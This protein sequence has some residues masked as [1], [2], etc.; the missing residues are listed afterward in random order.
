MR[1]SRSRLAALSPS[2]HRIALAGALGAS[3]CLPVW[4]AP[5]APVREQ[6]L[7]SIE[8]PLT[9][10]DAGR[11]REIFSLQATADWD[12][13]DRLIAEVEDRRLLGHVLAGRYL[14]PTDYRSRYR[15]L[16]AW[17]ERY[18]D[19]PD[20]ERIHKLAL[21]RKPE[22]SPP[23]RRPR[24]EETSLAAEPP[25]DVVYLYR[26]KKRLSRSDWRQ[27][28]RLKWRIRRN[29]RRVY[30]SKTERMLESAELRRLFDDF[31]RD[32]AYSQLAAA[33]L[34]YGK[35]DKARHLAEGVTQRAGEALPL[36]HWTAGL[37]AWR[38]GDIAAA[39]GHFEGLALSE[40][41]SSWNRSAGAYWAGRAHRRQARE[42]EAHRWWTLAAEF[43]TTFYG[44]MAR[45]RL[46][47]QTGM[48]FTRPSS[49]R[50]AAAR[51]AAA[52]G[53]ADRAATARLFA[54]PGAARA[55]ALAQA[56]E[57]GRAELE[58]LRLAD[59]R[60]PE[61][62]RPLLNLARSAGLPRLGLE[63]AHRLLDEDTP[64]WTQEDLGASLFPL[65]TWRP[66][67]GFALD[68]ALIYAFIRQESSFDPRAKSPDGARGLMQ[69]MP[70]TAAYLDRNH[71]F[72]GDERD[73]L[74]D[75]PLNLAL[76]QRYL[77]RLLDSR[78]VKHDLLRLA[79]AYNAGPGNLGK[80]ER[81]MDYGGDPLLFVE[82]LPT[83]ETRLFVERVLT[84]LWLYRLR[85]GQPAPSLHALASGEWPRYEALDRSPP[86]I[87]A[88]PP[89]E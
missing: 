67:G 34:Y 4:Q 44:L 45:H 80:W 59:W 33:W 61:V 52:R 69:L 29:L 85:L 82:S 21:A 14:H 37:A 7:R 32:E 76:G 31:E 71:H 70:R 68:R 22:G 36:A 46:N 13:A 75:P 48:T 10:A 79:V 60:E 58:M 19:H 86:Q 35:A 54:R 24:V 73:L 38:L 11:Y 23:P 28:R 57:R 3:L 5:A 53:A 16:A 50:G 30:L 56:G 42:A 78:R 64:S 74:Y 51:G 84:N 26:S 89:P 65:P 62:A 20:A 25:L 77:R 15:E 27:V 12:G 2:P 18:A 72:K 9:Q 81:R 43:P 17:L 87:S 6:D 8:R 66:P 55:A 49:A 41:A 83:L 63:I 40:K 1:V 88:N 47:L 39:A